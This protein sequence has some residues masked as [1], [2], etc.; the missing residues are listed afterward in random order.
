MT[1][2]IENDSTRFIVTDSF[3]E[4]D[5]LENVFKHAGLDIDPENYDVAT[6]N[7]WLLSPEEYELVENLVEC[8]SVEVRRP[9]FFSSFTWSVEYAKCIED[10][11]HVKVVSRQNYYDW[12]K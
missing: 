12:K 11:Y 6:E 1:I 7:G 9:R 8:L 10:M 5:L 2:F 4:F 3:E